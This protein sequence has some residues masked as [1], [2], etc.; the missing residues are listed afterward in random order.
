MGVLRPII[1]FGVFQ[2]KLERLP[3]DLELLAAEDLLVL[4]VGCLL[5][6]EIPNLHLFLL[7]LK[8][9]RLGLLDLGLALPLLLL[10]LSSLIH[11]FEDFDY[12]FVKFLRWGPIDMRGHVLNQLLRWHHRV[13]REIFFKVVRHF[14]LA[15]AT[16]L[17]HAYLVH[18]LSIRELA[19]RG[20][21]LLGI[22]F[23][24]PS[25]RRLRNLL[26]ILLLHAHGSDNPHVLV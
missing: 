2:L 15:G 3:L 7:G 10:W 1:I 17:L 12:Q 16:L 8:L 23:G 6:E 11:P 18:K 26:L 13:I 20:G 4:G 22:I 19:V 21:C 14:G 24:L 9:C 25:L 5:I